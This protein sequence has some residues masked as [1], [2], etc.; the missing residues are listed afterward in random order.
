MART[1]KKLTVE[2]FVGNPT[3]GYVQ[4]DALTEEQKERMA[5]RLSYSMSLY[6]T[7]HI[8]EYQKLKCKEI[9]DG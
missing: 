9:K 3:D 6:Y 4:V 7:Q 1:P 5:Q 8:S 2:I